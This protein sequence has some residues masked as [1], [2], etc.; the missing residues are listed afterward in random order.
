MIRALAGLLLCLS[1]AMLA[2][3]GCSRFGL[4]SATRAGVESDPPVAPALSID[5][6]DVDSESVPEE[7]ASQAPLTVHT[8]AEQPPE[9][10]D[11]RLEEAV[12]LALAN[13]QVMRELGVSVIR[14]PGSTRTIHDAAIQESDPRYGVEAALAAFDTT[15][16]AGVFGEKN[17]R[18]LNN[19]FLGGGTR[20][21]QQDLATFQA[22]LSKR[23]ATG[24]ELT[25]RNN[26]D[27]DANNAPANAFPHA[28]NTNIETEIRQPLLQGAGLDFNRIAGPGSIPGMY[29]G[30][31]VARTNTDITL[32]DF[33]TG[34]RNLTNDVENAY[35]DLYFAYR[36]LDAK[37]VARDASLATWRQ[38][39]AWNQA[40]RKG[41]EADKEALARE[42]YYRLQEEVQNA[43]S[44]RLIDGTRTN[45]GSGGGT[46]RGVGGV[47]T[48]ERRLRLMLGLPINDGRLIRP[49][50]EPPQVDVLFDW[51]FSLAEAL[52]RRVELRR[53]KWLV[54]RRELECLAS[55]NFTLPK[56]DA[57][58]RYRWRGF[59]RNFWRYDD[60]FGD[61]AVR[62]LFGGQFQEWMVGAEF[63]VPLGNRKGLAA[64]RNAELQ[65]AR[66]RAILHEQE[67]EVTLELSNMLAEKDR[68]HAVLQTNFN[69]RAA[70]KHE[71]AALQAAFEN[72]NAPLHLV[73]D[74]QRRVADAESQYARSLVEYA[75]AVKNV[76]FEKGSLLDYNGVYVSEGAWPRKACLDAAAL[77]AREFRASRLATANVQPAISVSRGEYPQ[78]I[79][80]AAPSDGV[81][82]PPALPTADESA[83]A[84]AV[85]PA[86]PAIENESP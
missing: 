46:F 61:N 41:G 47:H 70:A 48:A 30:V 9:T 66:E 64:V 5:M 51:D 43:L 53:Q 44:G 16:S 68:A 71:L 75:I 15:L 50:D 22:Q 69:R 10:W 82:V 49:A 21:L 55:E 60:N 33:E 73:L 24:T 40:Q 63:S 85:A 36:D 80:V 67:R 72:E 28:W 52:E 56:L 17:D 20:Q 37:V 65:L 6:P 86:P 45:N 42:Q 76:H 79:D 4:R 84:P 8:T 11:L 13:N 27:Y 29:N 57:V 81:T 12:Q 34:V 78:D 19:A 39:N 62:D 35:W 31:L 58:G 32:A 54:K 77:R 1:G 23:T 59:G 18:K 26:T 25:L 3:S 7:L 74:A 2:A 83:T 38:I 14:S